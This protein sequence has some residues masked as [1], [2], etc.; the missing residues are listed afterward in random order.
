MA[1][2]I[3][4][5]YYYILLSVECYCVSSETDDKHTCAALL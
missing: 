4:F 2:Q 1:S 5:V 3:I